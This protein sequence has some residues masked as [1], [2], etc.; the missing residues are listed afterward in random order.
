VAEL[1]CCHE[2]M[3]TSDGRAFW[4]HAPTK[5]D[6]TIYGIA[7]TF[8][9]ECGHLMAVFTLSISGRAIFVICRKMLVPYLGGINTKLVWSSKVGCSTSR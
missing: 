1:S 3:A 2:R 4:W 6:E 9:V 7:P 8:G 5:G